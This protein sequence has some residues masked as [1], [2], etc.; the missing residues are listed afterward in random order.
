M[1]PFKD[2]KLRSKLLAMVLPVVVATIVAVGAVVGYIADELAY[3]G[4]TRASQADLEH[5]GEF[6]LDLLNA[7]HQQ[8]QVYQ[9]DKQETVNRDLATL[10]NLAHGLAEAQHAQHRAGRLD[11]DTAAREARAAIKKVSVG[12]S[13]Y[14]YA[15]TSKGVLTAHVASEG[16]DISDSRD[17]SG[18]YFIREMCER[19]LAA[20]PGEVLHIVYPWKNAV[21]GDRH[22]RKKVVAYRYFAPWDWI[23]AAGSYLD[24]TYEDAS[25]ERRALAELKARLKAK[26]VGETG[27]IYAMTRRGDLTIHPTRE[28]QNLYEERDD[29]GRP[30]I[31]EMCQQQRGW[32]R[33]PWKNPEEAAPRMKLVRY[34]YFEPWD[35]IVAVGSYE[36]EFYREADKIRWRLLA[37][38]VLLTFIGVVVA[39]GLV[40]V[41]ARRLTGPIEG[42][43]GVIRQVKRGRLEEKMSVDS[44]DELGELAGAF[45]RMTDIL[46]RNQAMEATHEINN[47]LGVILGLSGY[48]EGKL[49]ADD[50]NREHI[51]EIRRESQRCKKIVQDLLSYARIPRPS[52]VE[53]DLNGLLEQILDFAAT[54]TDLQGVELVRSLAPGLPAVR[55]DPDQ[56]RQVA[57]TLILNAGAAMPD[58]GRVEVRTARRDDGRVELSIRDT[59][60]GIAPEHLEKVFEPFFTTRARGTGLGLPITRQIVERH[61]GEIGIESQL[62]RGTVVTVAL[63]LRPEET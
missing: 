23:I 41:A 14:L 12:A 63:P 36:D 57:N 58:G 42:M 1:R 20:P 52:L 22:P 40:V 45:N 27:Y 17:E 48:L 34:E 3:Q 9:Q 62:G 39:E 51:Q 53:T 30:F 25:F 32:I 18:R 21:L 47:P 8:F 56:I 19:A 4:M 15:M 55:L 6:A 2:W 44:G 31:R 49:A 24:E 38:M 7:H 54:H 46:K 11:R 59:G 43:I 37:S 50:P 16:A 13:G 5:M 35:W 28:G 33:Y 61:H 26:R 60:G 10:V 29:D